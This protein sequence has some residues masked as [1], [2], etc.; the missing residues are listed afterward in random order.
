MRNL[1]LLKMPKSIILCV[2]DIKTPGFI[3]VK[4]CNLP[5][6]WFFKPPV[7]VDQTAR[8]F[9]ALITPSWLYL[10]CVDPHLSCVNL[11]ANPV[12]LRTLWLR[13][14]DQQ[15]LSGNTSSFLLQLAESHH[16]ATLWHGGLWRFHPS[17][18]A[19]RQYPHTKSNNHRA[20]KHPFFLNSMNVILLHLKIQLAEW[21][22]KRSKIESQEQPK[23][24]EIPTP[25]LHLETIL[26]WTVLERRAP[27]LSLDGF[28]RGPLGH[29]LP[30]TQTTLKF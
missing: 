5:C 25:T 3:K 7:K 14:E 12:P 26:C 15:Q 22:C 21:E 11:Y 9:I 4:K 20:V 2:C 29:H 24:D 16:R 8:W 10:W 19:Q 28:K 27:G 23:G 13:S 1:A 30:P 6:G 17:A 18:S